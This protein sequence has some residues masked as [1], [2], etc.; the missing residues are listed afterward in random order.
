MEFKGVATTIDRWKKG[1]GKEGAYPQ[2]QTLARGYREAHETSRIHWSN[3]PPRLS[4]QI[5][6]AHKGGHVQSAITANDH[7]QR[8][9]Q[10]VL[11]GA[12]RCWQEVVVDMLV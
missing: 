3:P 4:Y 11:L 1:L 5:E 12:G 9:R 7:L 8:R 10:T 2:Q 6:L